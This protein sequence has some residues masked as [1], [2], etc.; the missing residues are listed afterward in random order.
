[1][2]NSHNLCCYATV[3]PP[4]SCTILH[5]P[6]VNAVL[7]QNRQKL[8]LGN[9]Q[10]FLHHI[11]KGG[12]KRAEST[13]IATMLTDLCLQQE[14][15]VDSYRFYILLQEF[16]NTNSFWQVGIFSLQRKPTS[17]VFLTGH[18]DCHPF[19]A[20]PLQTSAQLLPLHPSF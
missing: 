4:S 17:Q 11:E 5:L 16:T 10:K 8:L 14:M 7:E 18:C 20:L 9:H 3:L 2:T 15:L 19:Y 6:L 12:Q 13:A 1:M